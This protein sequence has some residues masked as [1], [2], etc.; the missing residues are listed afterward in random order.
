MEPTVAELLLEALKLM[1]IGMTTV[2]G[3]LLLLV[4]MLFGMSRLANRLSP[5]VPVT[6]G[7]ATRNLQDGAEG[8]RVAAAISAAVEYR[9]RQEP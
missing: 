3:F 4:G 2:Y 7:P 5:P 1:V 6:G 8:R 9:R